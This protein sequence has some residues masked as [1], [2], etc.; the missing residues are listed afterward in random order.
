MQHAR[1]VCAIA[2][3]AATALAQSTPNPFIVFPQ[4]PERMVITAASY[5]RR[6]D[7]NAAAEGL[8]EVALE[9]FRGVT[10]RVPVGSGAHDHRNE[11]FIRHN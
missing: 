6:P 2:V 4:D 3:V 8:Q 7:W 11:R 10:H 5:V 1:P 9:H